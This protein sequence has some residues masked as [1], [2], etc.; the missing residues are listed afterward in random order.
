VAHEEPRT[1]L[2]R[3]A[4]AAMEAARET[5]AEEGAT[6]DQLFI[7]LNASGQPGGEPNA[8]SA[9]DGDS[10]PEDLRERSTMIFSFLVGHAVEVGKQ[11]G[12][13]VLV[14]PIGHG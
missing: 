13:K 8:A 14:A 12:I 2:D 10:L 11:I 3:A 5:L 9:A 1:L 4:Q 7:T 6:L